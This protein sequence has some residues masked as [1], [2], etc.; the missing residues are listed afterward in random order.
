MISDINKCTHQYI[1]QIF[2]PLD[3]FP[4]HVF[5]VRNHDTSRQYFCTPSMDRI[6]ERDLTILYDLPLLFLDLLAKDNAHTHFRSFQARHD[7]HYLKTETNQVFFQIC[8]P[9]GELR[10]LLDRCYLCYGPMGDHFALG[11]SKHTS[12]DQWYTLSNIQHLTMDEED[13]KAH[14]LF[15]HILKNEFAIYPF[16]PELSNIISS[17]SVLKQLVKFQ[18]YNFS[19][20]ELECLEHLCRGKTYKQVG[21]E[22]MISPRTVETHLEHIRNK[23]TCNNKSEVITQFARYFVE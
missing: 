11:F 10:Y 13:Q 1:K 22:M 15:F 4:N 14:D 19:K 23:S 6:C 9:S 16:N 17:P 2:K 5:W 21:R 12:P 18:Q 8:T 20:R 7:N 3:D